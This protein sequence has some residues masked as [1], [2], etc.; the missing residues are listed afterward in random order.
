MRKV[1]FFETGS[2][3]SFFFFFF[4]FFVLFL[5]EVLSRALRGSTVE[6][7]LLQRFSMGLAAEYPSCFISALNFDIYVCCFDAWMSRN[8]SHGPNNVHVYESQQNLGQG[9]TCVRF[10]PPIPPHPQ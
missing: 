9:C 2:A 8:P 10:N 7:L 3:S 4:L 1:P 5:N 6:F